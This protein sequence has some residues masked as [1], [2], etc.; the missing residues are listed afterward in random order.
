M[1]H[2]PWRIYKINNHRIT[3]HK[4]EP[5][6]KATK[7]TIILHSIVPGSTVLIAWDRGNS[8][9]WD[10]DIIFNGISESDTIKIDPGEHAIN[11]SVIVRVRKY[12]KKPLQINN[13]FIPDKG[14]TIIINQQTDF[15]I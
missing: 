13:F 9:I 6:G 10:E 12:G 15:V 11:E 8:P 3:L 4:K 2:E 14:S 5:K 7:N 1:Y